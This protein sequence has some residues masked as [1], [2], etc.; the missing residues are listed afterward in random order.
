MAG[1]SCFDSKIY[2]GQQLTPTIAGRR[3]YGLLECVKDGLL[4]LH[5]RERIGQ[6]LHLTPDAGAVSAVLLVILGVDSKVA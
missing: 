5:R 6:M 2:V 1:C 4:T 3:G